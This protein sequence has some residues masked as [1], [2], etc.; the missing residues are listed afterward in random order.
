MRPYEFF[1]ENIKKLLEEKKKMEKIDE[2]CL[3]F[4]YLLF[5]RTEQEFCKYYPKHHGKWVWKLING[6]P[7]RKRREKDDR[8]N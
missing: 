1:N 8:R 7:N 3:S 6:Y 2:M 4:V 5:A